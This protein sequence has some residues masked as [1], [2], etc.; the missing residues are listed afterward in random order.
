LIRYENIKMFN[1]IKAK[2]Y[3]D[4]SLITTASGVMFHEDQDIDEYNEYF[5]KIVDQLAAQACENRW[6][7]YANEKHSDINSPCQYLWERMYIWFDGITNP[8]DVDYKS[9]LKTGNVKEQSIRE[10]W[11]GDIFTK[12]RGDHTSGNRYKWNP[13]DRCG[14]S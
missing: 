2:H 5:G 6:D 7:T 10:I 13:C 9:Y 14:L 8:C 4:S 12:L 11:H 1:D 3:I